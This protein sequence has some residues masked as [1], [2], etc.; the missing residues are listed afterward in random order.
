ML[1]SSGAQRKLSTTS[2]MPLQLA[3]VPREAGILAEAKN[4]KTES[5][6]Q[7]KK[8]R[9]HHGHPSLQEG[10]QGCGGVSIREVGSVSGPQRA[11]P[12]PAS[13][14][15]VKNSTH[16]CSLANNYVLK[17]LSGIQSSEMQVF[18]GTYQDLVFIVSSHSPGLAASGSRSSVR[19]SSGSP[20]CP[21]V[22][23]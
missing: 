20:V 9:A 8:V 4:R 21:V 12:C 1:L 10:Q 6:N 3:W 11:I 2:H 5:G 17:K 13:D 15:L 23:W 14:P 22:V 16:P 18:L 19:T 7:M